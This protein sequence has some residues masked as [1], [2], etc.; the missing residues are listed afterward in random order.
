[1][2]IQGVKPIWQL[3]RG[4]GLDHLLSVLFSLARSLS[5]SFLSIFDL[6]TP[7]TYVEWSYCLIRLT[8]PNLGRSPKACTPTVGVDTRRNCLTGV[9]RMREI[10]P[11]TTGTA[12]RPLLALMMLNIPIKSNW[13]DCRSL[14]Q[15]TS[16]II[17]KKKVSRL[18]PSYWTHIGSIQPVQPISPIKLSGIS[19]WWFSNILCMTNEEK[20]TSFSLHLVS[21]LFGLFQPQL[22]PLGA[23]GI[24]SMLV[25]SSYYSR[26]VFRI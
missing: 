9:R 8:P 2:T 22:P 23:I 15:D 16:Q 7:R 26:A 17:E 1:M 14:A 5:F 20:L 12:A 11:G 13:M 24:S 4:W 21:V 3:S 10:P 19:S 25:T 6:L 18:P